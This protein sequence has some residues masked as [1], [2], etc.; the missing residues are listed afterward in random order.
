MSIVDDRTSARK[1]SRPVIDLGTPE[2]RKKKL[3]YGVSP[4]EP[5][6]PIHL[7]LVRKEISLDQYN[8]AL[9]FH[10][11]R[12]KIWGHGMPVA[13]DP[14]RPSGARHEE[15]EDAEAERYDSYV[16]ACRALGKAGMWERHE[17]EWLVF[18][19]QLPTWMMPNQNNAGR[20][21]FMR[22]IAAILSW[23]DG[24]AR[25]KRD[26]ERNANRQAATSAG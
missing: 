13:L 20:N 6:T 15:I 8:A 18:D 1:R 9:N 22:A 23:H 5:A 19:E 7:L 10:Q 11:L 26:T 17:F 2:L 24:D 4:N 3:D 16:A 14:L 12:Q 21:A 25:R